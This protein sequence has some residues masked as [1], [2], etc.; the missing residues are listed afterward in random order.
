MRRSLNA[1]LEYFFISRILWKKICFSSSNRVQKR[2]ETI[3]TNFNINHSFIFSFILWP[4]FVNTFYC[5]RLK[6]SVVVLF[7]C[8]LIKLSLCLVML[9]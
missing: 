1:V 9:A 2:N 3:K 6:I 7:E 5:H 4:L 8:M